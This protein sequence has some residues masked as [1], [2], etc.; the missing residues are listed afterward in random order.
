MYFHCRKNS[1]KPQKNRVTATLRNPKSGFLKKNVLKLNQ[2]WGWSYCD[3]FQLAWRLQILHTIEKNDDRIN[4]QNKHDE[5][6][7]EGLPDLRDIFFFWTWNNRERYCLSRT[8][9]VVVWATSP[10]VT[11]SVSANNDLDLST[12]RYRIS[13]HLRNLYNYNLILKI[14]KLV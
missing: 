13:V 14:N 11:I 4:W 8:R 7:A 6:K 5:Y 1:R 2:R 12:M 3:V 10:V 9:S